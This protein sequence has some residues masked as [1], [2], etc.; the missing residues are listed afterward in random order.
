MEINLRFIELHSVSRSVRVVLINGRFSF[1]RGLYL[2]EF[3]FIRTQDSA[4]LIYSS[5]AQCT[6]I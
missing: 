5:P 3:Y 4:E 6:Q 1:S 2:C